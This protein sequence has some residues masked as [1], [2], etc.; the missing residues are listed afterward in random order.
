M[1][2]P[3]T[4]L[5]ILQ[6]PGTYTGPAVRL[7]LIAIGNLIETKDILELGTGE[8]FTALC[9]A[10]IPGARVTT[11]DKKTPNS[12]P[13]ILKGL[14]NVTF[15]QQD[16]LEFLRAQADESY[17]LI[18]VD[19]DHRR[20]H[21]HREAF[22]VRRTLRPEGMAVF[23]DVRLFGLEEVIRAVFGPVLIL[24]DV[25]PEGRDLGIALVRK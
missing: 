21:V 5:I 19:D 4:E 16:A 11:V 9:L 10:T 24:P 2:L 1:N 6:G 23:H 20:E 13:E 14:K 12:L 8:G 25:R 18:F 17:D 15:V 3:N 7:L 22:H